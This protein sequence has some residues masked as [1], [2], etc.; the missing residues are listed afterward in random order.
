M[1]SVI[2]D[3]TERV[4]RAAA[5]RTPLRIRGSGSKDFFGYKLEGEV[6]DVSAYRG[7]IDYEPSELV[8]TARTGT[9]LS[10][11]ERALAQGGHVGHIVA[12]E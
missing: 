9:P 6:L 5:E 12:G 2:N 1:N 8:M 7:V 3:L 4:R 10:E 11:I